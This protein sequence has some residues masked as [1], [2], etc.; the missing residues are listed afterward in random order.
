[1]V[2]AGEHER[3]DHRLAVDGLGDLLG[4]LLDDREQVG[5]ELALELGEVVGGR[6][7]QGSRELAVGA[8]DGPVGLD[9][10]VSG[11]VGLRGQAAAF[12]VLLARNVSP[13]SSVCW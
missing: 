9:A 5:E 2:I 3:L 10:D 4:M 1:V 7:L 8:V 6:G 11:A 12:C 13:S